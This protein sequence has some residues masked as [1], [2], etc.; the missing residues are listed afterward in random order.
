MTT[1][2]IKKLEELITP[3]MQE[4]MQNLLSNGFFINPD[5]LDTVDL[6][7][8]RIVSLGDKEVNND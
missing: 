5:R 4:R 6:Q 7:S 2:P 1:D 3:E 8:M